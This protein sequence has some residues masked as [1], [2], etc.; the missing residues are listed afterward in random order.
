MTNEEK[1]AQIKQALNQA[2]EV[3]HEIGI[4]GDDRGYIIDAILNLEEIEDEFQSMEIFLQ[5][6]PLDFNDIPGLRD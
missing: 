3:L 5:S 4:N 6:H 2:G 1:F